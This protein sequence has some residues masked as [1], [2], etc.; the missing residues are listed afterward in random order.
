MKKLL[1]MFGGLFAFSCLVALPAMAEEEEV[2]K[3]EAEEKVLELQPVAEILE[4]KKVELVGIPAEQNEVALEEGLV[5]K[6]VRFHFLLKNA[7]GEAIPLDAS[8]AESYALL[9]EN[10]NKRVED[11]AVKELA[12]E[13]EEFFDEAEEEFSLEEVALKEEKK[14][15]DEPIQK[16]K[17]ERPVISSRSMRAVCQWAAK[18]G[19]AASADVAD[20]CSEFGMSLR[21]P[22]SML[23]ATKATEKV[24]E[25]AEKK[26]KAEEVKK[27]EES[28]AMYK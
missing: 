26:V 23:M 10:F 8:K 27:A 28:T 6:Q 21:L 24:A 2:K 12:F 22:K 5:A 15:L 16:I 1:V 11:P 3:I 19:Y 17:L 25:R 9:L 14:A 7:R 18:Q 13:E 4:T 20:S